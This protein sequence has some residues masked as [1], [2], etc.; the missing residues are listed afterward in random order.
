MRL[1]LLLL[2]LLALL[3]SSNAR[4]ISGNELLERCDV[5]EQRRAA[6]ASE[7][8]CYGYAAGALDG[9]LVAQATKPGAPRVIC[10]PADAKITMRQIGLIAL[11]YLKA[12]PAS[13]HENA[14]NLVLASM[15]LAFPCREQ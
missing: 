6:P 10:V 14:E 15:I 4:A 3:F 8:F 2:L 12:H 5:L 11:Q 13:L 9:W 1:T 7:G